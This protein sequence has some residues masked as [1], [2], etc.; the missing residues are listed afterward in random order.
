MTFDEMVAQ[1]LPIFPNALFDE[2][3]EGEVV[4]S[5]GMRLDNDTLIPFE[6]M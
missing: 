5:T 3:N 4:I 6:G 1:V 2:G